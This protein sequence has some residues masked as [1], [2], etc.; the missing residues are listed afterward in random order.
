MIDRGH[1]LPLSRQASLLQLGR[2][3][4]YYMPRAVPAAALAVIAELTNCT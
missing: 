4:V 1:K 2:S 3:G